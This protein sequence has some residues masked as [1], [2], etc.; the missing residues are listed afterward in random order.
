MLNWIVCVARKDPTASWQ[1]HKPRG[2]AAAAAANRQLRGSAP[3]AAGG[4]GA[5]QGV[6]GE[7]GE[8]VGEEIE[9]EIAPHLKLTKMMGLWD[10]CKLL[11]R[12]E[13]KSCEMMIA[14]FFY[15]GMCAHMNSKADPHGSVKFLRIC[16]FYWL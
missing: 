10:F 6:R 12:C 15:L 14:K 8:D 2:M 16:T 7:V 5:G 9:W 13:M 4:A 1:G 11:G 3:A